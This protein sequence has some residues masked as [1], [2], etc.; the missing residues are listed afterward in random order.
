MKKSIKTFLYCSVVSMSALMVGGCSKFLDTKPTGVLTSDEAFK[1]T[2]EDE[3]ALTSVYDVLGWNYS[4]EIGEWAFGDV[5]SDDAFK[6]GES[7]A[8]QGD[9]LA[10]KNFNALNTNTFLPYEWSEPYVGIRRANMVID[11]VI[12]SGSD[13]A[14]LARYV[15][16]AK[17]LRAYYYFNLVKIF[18]GVPLVLHVPN[19]GSY[20]TPRASVDECWAQIESDLS[21]AAEVLPQKG[22]VEAGRA[23]LGAALALRTKACLF[24]TR[25]IT[26]APS[27]STVKSVCSYGT[28]ITH[29]EKFVEA[30]S[31]AVLVINSGKYDLDPDYAHIFTKDGQ[32]GIESIFEVEHVEVPVSPDA[33][34]DANEGQQTSIFQCGRNYPIG[35]YGFDCPTPSLDSA[36]EPGDLRKSATIIEEGDVLYPDIFTVDSSVVKGVKV[37]DTTYTYTADNS[38]DY[39]SIALGVTGKHSRKYL[40]EVHSQSDIDNRPEDS[41]FPANWR[42]IRY[43]DLLLM[44]A[45]A[46]NENGRSD[47]GLTYLNQV[48]TR[49]GLPAIA[50]GLST[51][52]MRDTIYHE[53]R[54]ELAM[55]GIRFFDVV[56]QGRGPTVLPG[57]VKGQHEHFPLPA[58]ELELNPTLKDNPY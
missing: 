9:M 49:A 47:L 46:T 34:G 48:R 7:D 15:G 22:E 44:Y 13:S 14:L 30:E 24:Q 26:S 29:P 17:F 41:N 39:A 43:S 42:S 53:R 37:Y 52:V 6:G 50:S 8:D 40:P 32:D 27:G 3:A 12:P 19:A 38:D 36:Y 20:N 35:G 28:A 18:G 51:V 5:C 58:A 45:E 56:R 54:V 4:Q 25:E 16:E 55:E 1:T 10:L 57:F 33:W 11:N 21:D 31:L 2:Q 23:T